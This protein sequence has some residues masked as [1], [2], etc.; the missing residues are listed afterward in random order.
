MPATLPYLAYQLLQD[1]KSVLGLTHKTVVSRVMTLMAPEG[2]AEAQPLSMEALQAIQASSR[3]LLRRDW[4]DMES[5]QYPESLLFDDPWGTWLSRYPLLCLDIP[6]FWDRRRRGDT[7]DLPARPAGASLPAYYLQNFHHQTDGYLSDHSARLYDL[8]VEILFNGLAGAMRRRVIA[9][10]RRGLEAFADRPAGACRILDVATGTGA[11]LRQLMGAFPEAQLLGLDLSRA[12]L[13]EASRR[14]GEVPGALPQVL[15]GNAEAMPYA[16]GSMQAVTNVFLLHELPGPVRQK[17]LAEC[18]RV[19]EPG[20]VLVL[21]DSVQQADAAAFQPAL[22]NFS[23]AFHEPFYNDYVRDDI[24]A[25]L[26]QAGFTDI[27]AES[28]F[29]TRVWSARRPL[30]EA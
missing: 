23:R 18:F 2:A 22:E 5:G 30:S 10:V 6:A 12:Y 11:T 25:R 29:M 17:V 3:E 4:Q 13:R 20:G 15:E 16:S 21:A 27:E 14:L 19:L 8:Q 24:P 1:G 7:R 28:H 9:P 26:A